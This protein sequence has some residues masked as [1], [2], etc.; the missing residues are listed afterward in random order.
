MRSVVQYLTPNAALLIKLLDHIY[1]YERDTDALI[2]T[3]FI[4]VSAAA[5]IW[6][7]K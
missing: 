1:K 4:D 3:V 2:P 7:N 6:N 5:T